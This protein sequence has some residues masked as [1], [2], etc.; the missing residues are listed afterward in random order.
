MITHH[1]I[2]HV[3]AT[4]NLDRIIS[5]PIIGVVIDGMIIDRERI[6]VLIM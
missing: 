3:I 5:I 6:A 1:M 2:I 4:W